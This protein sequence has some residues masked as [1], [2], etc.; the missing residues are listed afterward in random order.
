M[1]DR[2]PTSDYD[3]FATSDEVDLSTQIIHDGESPS[4]SA[5]PIFQSNTVGGVYI[6]MRNPTI[7]ALEE[8]VRRLERGAATVAFAS[9]MAAV[10]HTLFGLLRAGSRIVVHQSIFVGVQTLLNDFISMLGIDVVQ[11][12]LN[13]PDELA[14]AL[15]KPTQLV[16]FETLSN[17][18]LEL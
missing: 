17:P 18:T 14:R 6:R 9:G 11:A 2:G 10:S 3:F 8:K 12:D 16:Y 5:F 13:S 7:E 1:T 4:A 15:E